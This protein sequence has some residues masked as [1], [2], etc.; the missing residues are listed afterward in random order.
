MRNLFRKIRCW[1][2]NNEL[3]DPLQALSDLKTPPRKSESFMGNVLRSLDATLQDEMFVPP[4]GP[5]QVPTKF[6]VFLNPTDDSQ[7]QNKK[8][9]ALEKNLNDLIFERAVELAG[10]SSLSTSDIEVKIRVDQNLVHPMI[11]V[12]PFWDQEDHQEGRSTRSE[13]LTSSSKTSERSLFQLI[14]YKNEK[15]EKEIPFYKRFVLIGREKDP[16]EV[17]VLLEDPDISRIQACLSVSG[18]NRFRLT[19]YGGNSVKVNQRIVHT[20]E[21]VSFLAGEPLH[22]GNFKLQLKQKYL[23][24]PLVSEAT[25]N[26]NPYQTVNVQ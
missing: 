15:F 20:N 8:R 18:N 19:N 16:S 11:Q 9:M 12:V 3:V 26:R 14:V 4:K 5:A 2:D 1:L 7:W 22:I 17:D 25:R 23:A 6:I 21:T 10:T 13:N 24:Q